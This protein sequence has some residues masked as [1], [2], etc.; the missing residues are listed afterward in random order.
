MILCMANWPLTFPR[1]MSVTSILA[2]SMKSGKTTI[3]FVGMGILGVPMSLNL[4][5]AGFRVVVHNRNRSK[6]DPVIAAGAVYASS[7]KEVVQQSAYTFATLSGTCMLGH[8]TH[9]I[10]TFTST[11][12]MLIHIGM[13]FTMNLS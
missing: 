8:H 2:S 5:K 1:L 7:P 10:Q 6:C 13:T 11:I 12:F 9:P 4:I 3:G